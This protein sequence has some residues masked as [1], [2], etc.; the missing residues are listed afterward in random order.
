[1]AREN[2]AAAAHYS[3]DAL[4]DKEMAYDVDLKNRVQLKSRSEGKIQRF[5][6]EKKPCARIELPVTS[7]TSC[8]SA[9][10]DRI[11]GSLA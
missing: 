7:T 8:P 5:D 2:W 4:F 3:S 11:G 1:M 9:H 10:Q 6:K